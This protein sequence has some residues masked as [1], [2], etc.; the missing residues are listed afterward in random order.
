MSLAFIPSDAGLLLLQAGVVVGPRSVRPPAWTGRL[1]GWAWGLVPIASIVLVIFA[2]RYVSDTAQGLTWLALLAVPPL[3]AGALG[4][5]MRGARWWLAGLAVP[6]FL[7]A[8]LARG[9]LT[10]EAAGALLS[11]LSCVTLGV[12]LGTVTPPGWLKAGILLMAAADTWL[13]ASDLLQAPNATLVAAAP[14]GGLP[15]LQSETFGSANMGY[16]DLFVAALLG[17]VL[18]RSG[19]S[20]GAGGLLTLALAA[21]F[22]LL[23]FVVDE[24]PATVPVAL[25]LV[26]MEAWGRRRARAG[27]QG[28]PRAAGRASGRDDVELLRADVV[29]RAARAFRVIV[30]IRRFVVLAGARVLDEVHAVQRVVEALDLLA[31]RLPLAVDLLD[32][33]Q[34]LD[35]AVL[36]AAGDL[37]QG[38]VD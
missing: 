30:G 21:L 8:W 1:R 5:A 9:S 17:V 28:R 26:L 32:L 20:R 11:G 35:E 38:P 33:P 23:F 24:L 18:A 2:V 4:W 14:G 13:V 15:Q 19:R 12:L 34:V 25:A 16:G 36:D 22:D 10:G 31:E 7:L 29:A 37:D 3:A 6:L 27:G